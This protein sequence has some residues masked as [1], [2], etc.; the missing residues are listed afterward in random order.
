MLKINLGFRLVSRKKKHEK[1]KK[2]KRK[3]NALGYSALIK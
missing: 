2:R 3:K 1:K